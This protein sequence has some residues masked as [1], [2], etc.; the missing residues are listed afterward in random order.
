MPSRVDLIPSIGCKAKIF[1]DAHRSDANEV[2]ILDIGEEFIWFRRIGREVES[3]K[4]E[5][6]QSID[7]KT[8]IEKSIRGPF[9]EKSDG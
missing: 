5:Y 9:K 6:I 8:Q 2:V 1:F 4:L 3:T 7:Y